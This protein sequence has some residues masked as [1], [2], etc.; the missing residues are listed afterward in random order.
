MQWGSEG[1][2][3]ESVVEA[4]IASGDTGLT[5]WSASGSLQVRENV[6]VASRIED[7]REKIAR[8]EKWI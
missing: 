6:C 1:K 3:I 8:I 7:L 5:G 2:G 4:E